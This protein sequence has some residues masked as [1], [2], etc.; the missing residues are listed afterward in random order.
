MLS[1]VA[2]MQTLVRAGVLVAALVATSVV[3]LGVSSQT[4]A[5]D[6]F[7]LVIDG[8]D[9][10]SFADGADITTE[11]ASVDLPAPTALSSLPGRHKSGEITL[12]RGL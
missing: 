12:T 10:G 1:R 3:P 4:L 7:S 5:A 6:R 9:V 8:E 2:G 11:V